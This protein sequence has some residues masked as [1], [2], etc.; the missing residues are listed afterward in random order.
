M[1]A[2]ALVTYLLEL[3]VLNLEDIKRQLRRAAAHSRHPQVKQ[4]LNSV[5]LRY[6]VNLEGDAVDKEYAEY[7]TKRPRKGI[8]T[9]MPDPTK[10]PDWA[11]RNIQSKQKMH[12]FDPAVPRQ[13]SLW[14]TVDQIVD[15]FNT[16]SPTDPRVVRADRTGFEQAAQM[17][18]QWRAEVRKNPFAFTKDNPPVVKDFGDG[19]KFVQLVSPF[20]FKREGYR[21]PNDEVPSTSMGHCI[22]GDNYIRQ[23]QN[24]THQYYSLRD[25]RNLPYVTIEVRGDR[26]VIQIKGK[27]N[28]RPD[29]RAIPYIQQFIQDRGWSVSGDRANAMPRGQAGEEAP[30]G[31][32]QA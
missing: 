26:D 7:T 5:A 22:H 29:E 28:G 17:A 1:N 31:W 13:R 2:N 15:W 16:L 19:M 23:S 20:H 6:I 14:Q 12:F 8:H 32:G 27:R 9:D 21:T 30:R 4:W 25:E 24:G 11:Q 18:E 3:N 10:L